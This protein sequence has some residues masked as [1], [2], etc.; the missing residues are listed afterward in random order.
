[1]EE[2]GEKRKEGEAPSLNLTKK[3][4]NIQRKP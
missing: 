3:E 1:M 2:E 4:V